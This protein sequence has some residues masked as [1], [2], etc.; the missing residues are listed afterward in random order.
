MAVVV[1]HCV[2]TPVCHQ[3]SSLDSLLS[4]CYSLLESIIAFMTLGSSL[5]LEDRQI[6]QLH[7]AMVGAFNAVVLFLAKVQDECP[8]QVGNEESLDITLDMC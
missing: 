3:V 1:Y 5:A 2:V 8:D 6:T 4:T 7:A